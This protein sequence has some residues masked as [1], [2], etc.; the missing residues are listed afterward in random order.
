M[1]KKYLKSI[2]VAGAAA[3]VLL[4]G[5][6]QVSAES[7]MGEQGSSNGQ[8]F[9]TINNRIDLLEIDLWEAVDILQGQIDDLVAS[10]VDHDTLIAAIQGA[11]T[12]LEAR[13]TVNEGNISTLQAIQVIQG[14][15]IN[16]LQTDLTALEARVTVNEGDITSLVLADQALNSLIGAINA[17]LL[18]INARITA[19][20]G[21]ISALQTT[22]DSLQVQLNTLNGQLA[23]KQSRVNGYCPAGNSI[24]QINGDGTVICELDN[25]SAGVGTLTS[26]RS[27]TGSINIAQSWITKTTRSTSR[28]CASGYRAT[29][30]GYSVSGNLGVGNAYRSYPSSNATWSVTVVADSRGSTSFRAYVVCAKVQ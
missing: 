5:S 8:P 28:S 17:Q 12:V 21:D 4:C 25:V 26:Y 9:V 19:N 18:T 7:G 14:Q 20:D 30:G 3:I 27:Y 29:G 1:R 10:D 15:L 22:V 2:T 11:V 23:L 13:V 6:A 24:R 16:V